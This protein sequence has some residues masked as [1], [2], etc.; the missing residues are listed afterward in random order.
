MI[1]VYGLGDRTFHPAEY[2]VR[3]SIT[4]PTAPPTHLIKH[5][6]TIVP[7]PKPLNLKLQRV[8]ALG[9]ASGG[10]IRERGEVHQG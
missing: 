3:S 6:L 1:P 5:I 9:G 7:F 10:L 4:L 2:P 8:Y